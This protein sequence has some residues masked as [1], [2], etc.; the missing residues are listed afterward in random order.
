MLNDNFVFD[1][2]SV[3]V[4]LKS[5]D[6]FTTIKGMLL[7]KALFNLYPESRV[8]SP[9]EADVNMPKSP[10]LAKRYMADLTITADPLLLELRDQLVSTIGQMCMVAQIIVSVSGLPFGLPDPNRPDELRAIYEHFLVDTSRPDSIWLALI[11]GY[12]QMVGSLVER[13]KLPLDE[14]PKQEQS[15]DFLAVTS[16]T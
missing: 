13:H 14:I 16:T 12:N 10:E 7:T 1:N 6:R 5:P 4:E 8:L 2:G 11:R 15:E 9:Q 3:R